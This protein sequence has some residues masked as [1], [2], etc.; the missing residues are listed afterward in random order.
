M[1]EL[2]LT[3]DQKLRFR[4]Y[5]NAQA[6]WWSKLYQELNYSLMTSYLDCQHTMNDI[7]PVP[8]QFTLA[9]VHNT[10]LEIPIIQVTTP[11]YIHDL[12]P[13]CFVKPVLVPHIGLDLKFGIDVEFEK[14]PGFNFLVGCITFDAYLND[15]LLCRCTCDPM[16]MSQISKEFNLRI[17]IEPVMML[18]PFSG[19]I[20]MLN[21]FI[22]GV[23]N[24]IGSRIMYG[25]RSTDCSV[26]RIQ[27]IVVADEDGFEV[28]WLT[29]LLS[30]L[31]LESDLI[32]IVGQ[33]VGDKDSNLLALMIRRLISK[34][35]ER[36]NIL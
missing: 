29:E 13:N 5:K 15:A 2:R 26:L 21:G 19:P 24:A 4:T 3:S 1:L 22:R 30:G 20:Y 27:D 36:I 16:S 33:N 6:E 7:K 25:E 35:F 12:I 34:I 8:K 23:T 9:P 17:D 32:S 31:D 10:I 11:F 14:P 28:L 18:K